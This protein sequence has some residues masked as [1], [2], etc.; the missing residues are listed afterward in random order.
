MTGMLAEQWSVADFAPMDFIPAAVSL[1]TYDSR[2]IR[3][4][5]KHFQ[6]FINDVESGAVKLKIGRTFSLPQIAEAHK[7]MEDNAAGGK[8]VVVI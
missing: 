6:E 1:T 4:S 7:L 3:V 2:Q 5:D 8:I